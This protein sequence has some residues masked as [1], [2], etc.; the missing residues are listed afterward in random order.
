MTEKGY[1]ESVEELINAEKVHLLKR[2]AKLGLEDS[3]PD[4]D[5]FFGIALSGGGVRSATINLG[6]LKA[7]QD[8]GLL[9]RTDYLSSVSGGGYAGSY[10]QTSLKKDDDPQ[11]LFSKE[12][13]EHIQEHGEYLTPRKGWKGGLD[14]MIL[15]VSFVSS[16]LMSWVAPLTVLYV[17][18]ILY[19]LLLGNG[20]DFSLLHTPLYNSYGY[21][22]I[23]LMITL[24]AF[25]LLT[26]I[27]FVLNLLLLEHL[28]VS[29][30]ID[31]IKSWIIFIAIV[32]IIVPAIYSL[33][34][35][36]GNI[37]LNPREFFYFLALLLWLLL[38]G[39]VTDPNALSLQRFYK[40][41]LADAFMKFGKE[42]KNV[43]IADLSNLEGE[44]KDYIAPYP[45]IN[46][47][48]NLLKGELDDSFEGT[49]SH[50]YFLLSPLYCGSKLTGYLS[51]R[52]NNFYRKLR[53]PTAVAISAAAINP[54]M[55]TY[56]S[57]LLSFFTT[58]FN[59]R[60]GY[61]ALNP[62]NV[63][64]T[65]KHKQLKLLQE[66]VKNKEIDEKKKMMMKM[67]STDL[68]KANF[69]GLKRYMMMTYNWVWWPAYFFYELLSGINTNHRRLNISD[70][71]H[72]ENLGV[73]ELLRR[74]CKLIIAV[75]AG[76]DPR[77]EFTDL[78]NL[79]IRARNEL[80]IIL[81][82]RR[83]HQPEKIIRPLSSKG[84][85]E[86]HFAIADIVEM[87]EDRTKQGKTGIFVYVKSSLRAPGRIKD[88]KKQ[89]AS[90][91]YKTYHAAFPHE[92]TSDQFFDKAQWEAYYYLGFFMAQEVLK[93]PD[94][95]EGAPFPKTIDELYQYFDEFSFEAV[96]ARGKV[97]DID[98]ISYQS[99]KHIKEQKTRRGLDIE[100]FSGSTEIKR[101]KEEVPQDIL[102]EMEGK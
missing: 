78:Q 80:G 3:N 88:L 69:K 54:G 17:L 62:K 49:K 20:A 25:A 44:Q 51:T 13:R 48:L 46:T 97:P 87:T 82:F 102:D 74:R 92:P 42:Y 34:S 10:V 91:I 16:F 84:F 100:T 22:N 81:D 52:A 77:F 96:R 23:V 72:I 26:I 70:G 71:G 15:L 18:Y 2:R 32:L 67:W 41:R 31:T 76:S 65:E 14:K 64:L 36:I 1:L 63:I 98:V 39:F 5:N 79:V 95:G 89:S 58:I 19:N 45:L 50:D 12:H 93:G 9:K 43:R 27:Q 21:L 55:G 99:Y 59:L 57:P 73:Y 38:L 35:K 90:Y 24:G 8:A 56:S 94:Y 4:A 75:D 47:C 68:S 85:S 61:W 40:K 33:F 83:G 11:H 30:Y 86:N 37:A 6:F 28:S 66:K 53:L 101:A 60:F 7:F 29:F